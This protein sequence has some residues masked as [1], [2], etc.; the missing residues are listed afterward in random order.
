MRYFDYFEA[1]REEA[2]AIS[3][4]ITQEEIVE[5]GQ[6]WDPQ[7]FHIDPVA[8][9]DSIFGGLVAS[10]VHL[11][12]IAVKLGTCH[13][14]EQRAAAVSALGF[15]N[16]H[17]KTPARVGDTLSLRIRVIDSRES[18]SKPDVG[19][20]Q[21]YHEL[22]NQHGDIVFVFDDAFLVKKGP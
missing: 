14:Q 11:F 20:V 3:H 17:L 19:I 18:N 10:S 16:M 9:K 2:F 15:T 13:P 8:A 5:F 22:Y 21:M 1:G 12:A 7:P 6:R 4:T